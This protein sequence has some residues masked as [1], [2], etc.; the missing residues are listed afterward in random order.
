M[1]AIGSF[2]LTCGI[3]G[4]GAVNRAAIWAAFGVWIGAFLFH[5]PLLIPSLLLLAGGI[6]QIAVRRPTVPSQNIRRRGLIRF[7]QKVGVFLSAGMTLWRAIESAAVRDPVGFAIQ[8]YAA[9]VLGL[10]SPETS[11]PIADL[12][13]L[14][15]LPAILGTIR[16]GFRHGVDHHL[17]TQQAKDWDAR[18][19][20]EAQ[21]RQRRDPLWL[22]VIPALLLLNVLWLFLAPLA[23]SLSAAWLH[24]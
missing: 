18:L 7:W 15:E 13:D 14:P 19:Q 21:F 3:A 12:K 11:D 9:E 16:H 22:S 6:A 1:L 24:L 23:Q 8:A 10:R 20:F 2:L 5:R 17:I 4:R